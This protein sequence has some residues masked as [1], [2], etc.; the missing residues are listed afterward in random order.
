MAKK[1]YQNRVFEV[2]G[3]YLCF[4]YGSLY[5]LKT[6]I[7]Q[8][9]IDDDKKFVLHNISQIVRVLQ[10]SHIDLKNCYFY[11]IILFYYFITVSTVILSERAFTGII[12]HSTI[13]LFCIVFNQL[14]KMN[15]LLIILLI[16]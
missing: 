6:N 9:Y 2:Y 1:Y 15:N 10:Y 14:L 8:Y 3:T 13:I 16:F 11:R 5:T 7:L 12:L 4:G